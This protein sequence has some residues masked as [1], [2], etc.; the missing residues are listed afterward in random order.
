MSA[1]AEEALS[2]TAGA[3]FSIRDRQRAA[4]TRAFHLNRVEAVAGGAGAPDSRLPVDANGNGAQAGVADVGDE[5]ED[6]DDD[7]E[8][9][10]WKVV[11]F[12]G[13]G[14]DVL[15]PLFKVSDLRKH[16]IT[17]HL[18]LHTE[19]QP[20]PD[21]PAVYLLS[22]TP[23][24]IRRLVQD[25]QRSLYAK[26][27][28]HFLAPIP[29]PLLEQLADGVVASVTA[30]RPEACIAR[31]YDLYANFVSLKRDLFTLLPSVGA[32]SY[33]AMFHPQTSEERL[34]GRVDQIA[35]G[36]F[37]VFVTLHCVPY[38]R[39][40]RHGPAEMVARKLDAK[41]REYLHSS[42]GA[43]LFQPG[44]GAALDA[45][46]LQ[47]PLLALLDRDIDLSI[48]LHHGWTYECLVHDL[49]QY[50]Q[51]RVTVP[52]DA[53][54]K[55]YDLDDEADAFWARNAAL[56]FPSVA[57][58]IENE[59]TRYK[60]RVQEV[61]ARTGAVGAATALMDPHGSG[62]DASG[63]NAAAAAVAAAGGGS[64]AH[65]LAEAVSELP[66][67]TL[68]KRQID[69]HT[70]IASALLERIKQRALDSFFHIEDSMLS[71]PSSVTANTVMQAIRKG[72]ATD[73]AANASAPPDTHG[74]PEDRLRLFLMYW[75]L[76][77]TPLSVQEMAEFR[78]ALNNR[79]CDLRPL[80]YL[81]SVQRFARTMHAPHGRQ[82]TPER[83]GMRKRTAAA[84]A[85][86][87]SDMLESLVSRV[88]E[89]GHKGLTQLASTV[90]GL[91]PSER[92]APVSQRVDAWMEGAPDAPTDGS[93][94]GRDNQPRQQPS[95]FLDP[96]AATTSRPSTAPA[97]S[98]REAVV[99]LVGGGC[100]AEY[101]NLREHFHD[102]RRIMYG[103]TEMVSPTAFL[104]QL[105]ELGGSGS[106]KSADRSV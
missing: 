45:V 44:A 87:G 78:G 54:P 103:A 69:M 105:S 96:K 97:R 66:R 88:Y 64:G 106:T 36:L 28:V 61:N 70:N 12:D 41:F 62:G 35:S 99:F 23:D 90:K 33:A 81:Q 1:S 59:L 80:E 85:T 39:C 100:Y 93:Q 42:R 37:A 56:P 94:S 18:S 7:A 40:M 29:R 8:D 5:E 83:D 30:T 79:H 67:L 75:M 47:R 51:N 48:M 92:A 32:G 24:A 65:E 98:F 55:A 95:L 49:M 71:R 76:S 46:P 31:V 102:G 86:T 53:R 13:D 43:A 38:I 34:H 25:C 82:A 20:I 72:A 73:A 16:G 68:L 101:Q 11:V 58:N 91:M 15:A 19:R 14:R 26:L 84:A 22:A 4:L 3:W 57:E 10:F 60:R 2:L 50:A 27:Y 63:V 74:T 52:D 21:V 9:T 89:H 77:P 6:E 104:Q 17:L